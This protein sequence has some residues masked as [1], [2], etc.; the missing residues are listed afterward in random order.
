[1]RLINLSLLYAIVI[2]FEQI[3]G[4]RTGQENGIYGYDKQYKQKFEN[5]VERDHCANTDL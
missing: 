5:L 1:M 3:S 2:I 4:Y